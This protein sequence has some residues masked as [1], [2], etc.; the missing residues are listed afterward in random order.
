MIGSGISYFIAKEDLGI[1]DPV[2]KKICTSITSD[3]QGC[4]AV[5]TAEESK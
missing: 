5:V 1:Y 4:Q 2:A 3:A